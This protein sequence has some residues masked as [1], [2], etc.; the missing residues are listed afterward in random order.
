MQ[1]PRVGYDM[2]GQGKAT[3]THSNPYPNHASPSPCLPHTLPPPH[4]ASAMLH[5]GDDGVRGAHHISPMS[6]PYLPHISPY[7]RR[8]WSSWC[9]CTRGG[10]P[11]PRPH[12]TRTLSLSLS[13]SLTLTLALTLAPN[14]T[15]T[16]T[17]TRTLTL[18]LALTLTLT[19]KP[20]PNPNPK[21]NPCPAPNPNQACR[22]Q[23]MC[24]RRVARLHRHQG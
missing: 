19:L 1:T 2:P 11:T 4:H 17:L 3:T 5:Q 13:L 10:A 20:N 21:P 16:R 18:A 23:D 15:L 9:A 6:S 14:L 12:L 22:A 8:R 24:Q 7:L